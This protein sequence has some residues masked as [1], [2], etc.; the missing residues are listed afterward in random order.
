MSSSSD[1]FCSDIENGATEAAESIVPSK[2]KELYELAYRKF[3]EWCNSK[4]TDSVC[5]KVV[6]SYFNEKGKAM[7][8]STLW[9]LYS[10]LKAMIQ[11]KRNVDISKYSGVLAFLKRKNIGHVAKKT[12]VLS[13]RDFDRYVL[14]AEDAQHLL[15]KVKS[16]LV[17][18]E[19]ILLI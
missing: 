19:L 2:S 13:R 18:N 9:C 8:S 16:N 11:L 6:V 14:E 4:K 7:K 12:D 15:T 10:K 5:E 17:K 3:I 1:E